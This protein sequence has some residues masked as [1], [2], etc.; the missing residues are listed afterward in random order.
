MDTLTK[1]ANELRTLNT[2]FSLLGCKWEPLVKRVINL[3]HDELPFPGAPEETRGRSCFQI[4]TKGE[5]LVYMRPK[6]AQLQLATAIY[7]EMAL[8]IPAFLALLKARQIGFSTFI[9]LLNLAIAI[10]K[11]GC[12]IIVAAHIDDSATNLFSIYQLGYR[13]LRQAV[14]RLVD[15]GGENPFPFSLDKE[16]DNTTTIKLRENQSR[17]QSFVA[18]EGNM[19][20]STSYTAAHCSEFALWKNDPAQT[21][22]TAL[23]SISK[24]VGSMVFIETTSRGRGNAFHKLWL[25]ARESWSDKRNR[26][27]S[28][29]TPWRPL[30]FNW[31]SDE[32]YRI[33]PPAD[34]VKSK[35]EAEFQNI[36]KCDDAQLYWRNRKIAEKASSLGKAGAVAHFNREN[37]TTE[38]DAFQYAGDVSFDPVALDWLKS[39]FQIKDANTYDLALLDVQLGPGKYKPYVAPNTL[40]GKLG[41]KFR[42]FSMPQPG[43]HYFISADP[44]RNEGTNPDK[45]AF[46]V[47]RTDAPEQ[48]AL[49]HGHVDPYDFA[50]LLVA[51]GLFY[52][53]AFLVPESTGPGLGTCLRIK[54]E[55]KYGTIYFRNKPTPQSEGSIGFS[56]DKGTKKE[57]ITNA[58][59]YVKEL[60]PVIHDPET[61]LEIEGYRREWDSDKGEYVD[62]TGVDDNLAM[63]LFIGL[64]VGNTLYGWYKKPRRVLESVVSLS[65]E[66]S[67]A[68]EQDVLT[69]ENIDLGPNPAKILSVC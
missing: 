8:G 5:G 68:V 58:Q 31:M 15:E 59:R 42:I 36:H 19:G 52:N 18:K 26:G 39:R 65:P 54:K 51:A 11:A 3:N 7:E 10:L 6:A 27:A 61:Y 16:A 34:W 22:A 57:M 45:A 37:P 14:D 63:A 30:F 21:L 49:W 64:Y 40:V 4:K 1:T 62:V 17:M 50:D 44:T 67:I 41:G 9:G 20:I 43:V 2:A 33:T 25:A 69:R 13:S 47:W 56:T 66:D 38:E 46:H 48:V 35:E 28:R 23:D 53:Y 55:L 60:R 32:D 12:D 24:T 29:P